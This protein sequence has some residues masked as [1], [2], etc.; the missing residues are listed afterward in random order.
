MG[1]SVCVFDVIVSAPECVSCFPSGVGIR[2]QEI[3]GPVKG[4]GFATRGTGAGIEDWLGFCAGEIPF[5]AT[6]IDR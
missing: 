4:H 2:F 3:D 6:E 5:Q 1:L